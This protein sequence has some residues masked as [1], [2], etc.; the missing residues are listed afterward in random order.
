MADTTLDAK[1]EDSTEENISLNMQMHLLS[2]QKS[3]ERHRD[4]C[5]YLLDTIDEQLD[6]L[7]VEPRPAL[8]NSLR[9]EE[10][11]SKSF[12]S[13]RHTKDVEQSHGTHPGE[14]KDPT[15]VD[16]NEQNRECKKEEYKWRLA[17]LLGS[18]QTDIQDYHSDNSAESVCTEDFAVKFKQGMIEPISTSGANDRSV[19]DNEEY[20]F[21]KHPKLFEE[22][23]DIAG[24][25]GDN[26][27]LNTARRENILQQFKEELEGDLQAA[28]PANNECEPS[29]ATRNR[30]DS[31]ESLG[32]R[33]SRLSQVN[34]SEPSSLHSLE[35]MSS[36]VSNVSSRSAEDLQQCVVSPEDLLKNKLALYSQNIV[37][38]GDFVTTD[39]QE[40]SPDSQPSGSH[41]KQHF[42]GKSIDHKSET[43]S[44]DQRHFAGIS[45]H[46]TTPL[47][48]GHMNHKMSGISTEQ[49]NGDDIGTSTH[50]AELRT[51]TESW[52]LDDSLKTQCG[53]KDDKGYHTAKPAILFDYGNTNG[54]VADKTLSSNKVG[55]PEENAEQARK[56]DFSQ[57]SQSV[58]ET[59]YIYSLCT[60]DNLENLSSMDS[61]H[62]EENFT[63]YKHV[64]G[65]PLK[66]FDSV[67]VDSDLD[68]VTTERVRDHIRKALN[69]TKGFTDPGHKTR[70]MQRSRSE[71]LSKVTTDDDEEFETTF[72][73]PGWRCGSPKRW[74]SSPKKTTE[75]SREHRAK[76]IPTDF[77]GSPGEGQ[78]KRVLEDLA[79]ERA[80]L[81]ESVAKLRREA[82]MEEERLLQRKTQCR[83]A[84]LSL[85]D[86]L[87][88]KQETYRELES[89]R[90][91]LEKTQKDMMRME[92]RVRE[93]QI[94]EEGLRN[95]L[96]VLE[97]K[98]DDY[99]KEL[100]DLELELDSM[101][102]QNSSTRNSQMASF[103]YEISS[104]TSERDELKAHVRHLESSLSFME[105]QEL[106]RQLSSVKSELFSEQRTARANIENLQESLEECQC[107]LE[108][109]ISEC[110]EKQEKHKQL[111][112]QLRELEKKYETQI[113]N[114]IEEASDQKEVLN[115]QV[116]DMT[117]Q[118]QEQSTRITSLEK[119]LSE[120]ELDLLRLR[121]V[122]STL[123]A[124]KE[125]QVLA[126]EALKEEQN[127]R[128]L[129]LQLQHQ[130]DKE[131]QIAELQKEMQLQ[132]QKEIQQ[133]A[134]NMEQLKLK[135]LQDQA[136]SLRKET[137]KALKAIEGKDKDI[138]KLKE[139]LRSQKESMKKLAAELKQEAREMVHNTLL[140]EQKKW[141]SE[142]KDAL[143]IQR[144]T[145][146]EEKLREMADLRDSLE[147]ERRT[148]MALEKK[149]S[150]LQNIIQEHEIHYRSLQREK[151][152]ALDDLRAVLREEKQEEM[153]RL[154]QELALEKE[155]DV[156]R[157]KVRLQQ[158][159]EEQHI[160]RAE[161]N[162]CVFREREAV[163]QAERAERALGREISAA[164]ER[165]LTTLGR[166]TPKS[167]SHTRHGSPSRLSTN[168]A[169]QM[170]HSVSEDTNQYIHELQQD[171]EA[172]KRTA[173]H[174]QREKERELQQVKEHMQLE[175]EKALDLLKERLIQEH[176][177]EITNLQ[178]EQLRESMGPDGQSLRQQLREK[179]NELRAIQRNMAKWKDE[180]AAKLAVKFEEELNAELEKSL[181]RSK[182]SES[183]RYAERIGTVCR[184][185]MTEASSHAGSYV[186]LLLL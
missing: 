125:G 66:S 133:L 52:R 54:G 150:D 88:K 86:I 97:Y 118:V 167:P 67:T 159:E 63:H 57:C 20:S 131:K 14:H 101:R 109:K 5:D 46:A 40:K 18:E 64:A 80:I 27:T 105:R 19:L 151:Q 104:L 119:I 134:E 94:T 146:E 90:D 152:D 51:H 168:Q 102:Q 156:E 160:L 137:D 169:L 65:I 59:S 25:T 174:V 135:A 58:V 44:N 83:E 35:K 28:L 161:K 186:V 145:M 158:L 26:F 180:T 93:T 116:A 122:I 91:L 110:A 155:R 163:A 60:K 162:E 11:D 68:S 23:S 47:L 33:I 111:K 166:P 72:H 22:T 148:V 171:I 43:R 138:T 106:E 13:E 31:L 147:Q 117:S 164:C 39:L 76:S 89:L 113:Q 114:Q 12:L 62:K 153:R 49:R 16:P 121:D 179:D 126:F 96:V 182:A 37:E 79:T 21:I 81:E 141:E 95:E 144:H 53:K 70:R 87:G 165:I 100:H 170:L 15:T 34:I 177:E 41:L 173:I 172:Q 45:S 8:K 120:K 92:S 139:T 56:E 75:S 143:Q 2:S 78:F 154:E 123:K 73:S 183:H 181:S 69:V 55:H 175:K 24:P 142:K 17:H 124:D 38:K 36:A 149:A 82:I 1:F 184:T 99:L 61:T 115:Q 112:S 157:L 128:V 7:R 77:M 103:Q 42:E 127:K 29:G 9:N 4:H 129:D 85:N 176:I 71:S 6:Q 108:E 84:D 3:E 98:R 178:R 30:R 130:Q 140:R 10:K 136:E 107:K 74:N 48:K 132:K 32:G 185:P 50:P